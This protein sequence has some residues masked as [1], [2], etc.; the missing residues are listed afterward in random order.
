MAMA[1][2]MISDISS[3]C[4]EWLHFDRPILF[5]NPAPGK[6]KAGTSITDNTYV[7]QAGDVLDDNSQILPLVKKNLTLDAHKKARNKLFQYAIYKPDGKATERQAQHILELLASIKDEA[8]WLLYMKGMI[9]IRAKR[10]LASL[11][12]YT[13]NIPR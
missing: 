12:R 3:V 1:D 5:A 11:F 8:W 7:W 2:L 4:Y 13:K 10:L 9:R 6:Y